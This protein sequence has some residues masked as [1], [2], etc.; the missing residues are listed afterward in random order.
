MDLNDF[1]LPWLLR[2][3]EPSA[4][5]A[6]YWEKRPLTLFRG[7][8]AYFRRVLSLEEMDHILS[9]DDLRHPSIQLVKNSVP[10]PPAQY[11]TEV[12]VKGVPVG[13]VIDRVRMFAEYQQGATV[14]LDHLHRGWAPL[15]RLCAGLERLFGHPMQTNVYLTPPGAQ[16]FTAHYDT[17]D[18]FI[19]Q[20]AGSKRWRLYAAPVQLPLPNNPYPYPGPDPGKPTADFVLHAGDLLY[21]PRGH[22]H[23]AATSDSVSLH[24]TVGI[25]TYT[26][27]D[28]F[29]EAL[30]VLCQRDVRFRRALPVGFAVDRAA[31]AQLRAGCA[32]LMRELAERGLPT[33]QTADQLAER[34]LMTRPPLLEG[35]LSGLAGARRLT[36]QSRVCKRAWLYRLE[37]H[38]E[39]VRLLYHAKGLTFAR[40]MEPALRFILDNEAFTAASLPGNLSP[41]T[42][43]ELVQRLV[44]EGFL[45]VAPDPP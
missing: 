44:E 25:N 2:P 20:A 17:H 23:D 32:A 29:M 4:F 30:G 10:L 21:I 7:E 34:F 18:V 26:Y 28:L 16:G 39:A 6:D 45:T 3:V 1:G 8:E 14:I 22:V 24:V 43:I 31:A 5:F 33:D 42:R 12:E 27:A 41:A 11:T 36:P 15:A 13:G 37:V 40:P 38:G 19:L 35:H 9:S